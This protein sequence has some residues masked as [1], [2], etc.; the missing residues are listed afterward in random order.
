LSPGKV[1]PSPATEETMVENDTR[2]RGRLSR[3][4]LLHGLAGGC[5]WLALTGCAPASGSS[6]PARRADQPARLGWLGTGPPPPGASPNT[7]SFFQSF[8]GL[9]YTEGHNYTFDP[10]WV[11]PGETDYNA[12]A[13]ELAAA[14]ADVIV[15][16]ALRAA[17]AVRK[18]TSTIPVVMI[19]GDDPI[20]AGLV[21]SLAQPGGNVTGL[22]SLGAPLQGKRLELL[23]QA[24]P[25]MTKTAILADP[26]AP[27]TDASLREAAAAA[28]KLGL[29]LQTLDVSVPTEFEDAFGR[30]RAWGAEGF[31]ILENDVTFRNRAQLA[32]LVARE[33]LPAIYP[34]QAYTTAGGLMSYGANTPEMFGRAAVYVD[35]IL[36]GARPGELPV[37]QPA[38]FDLVLNL[39]V[40]AELGLTFPRSLLVNANQAIQ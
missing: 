13:A 35:K 33:R 26:E 37:E 11:R 6:S 4:Q 3:R 29:I 1:A 9:G 17:A 7:E 22:A 8:E 16:V 19:V 36:K 40:A 27:D 15:A 38:K 30:A 32:A 31:S 34:S 28:D 14:N 12:L 10:R 20:A 23:K 24:V 25:A 5:C 21:N 2:T 39:K 18:A